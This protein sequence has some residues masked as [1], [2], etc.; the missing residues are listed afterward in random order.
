[1]VNIAGN[2]AD[3]NPNCLPDT[4]PASIGQE[5]GETVHFVRSLIRLL[6]IS[7]SIGI[8][9]AQPAAAAHRQRD[10]A[11]AATPPIYIG[12]HKIRT[13]AIVDRN[14]LLVPV[15]GVFEAV[16]ASVEYSR[17]KF[18]VVR[19]DGAVIAAFMLDRT[20]AVVGHASVDLDVA[21]MRRDGRVYV[22]L[23]VVAEAAGASVA[24]TNRPPAVHIR[25]AAADDA[26][27]SDET[28][29]EQSPST[30]QWRIG[31]AI[32]TG[33]CA[34]GCL[35]L[36]VRRFAPGVFRAAPLRGTVGATHGAAVPPREVVAGAAAVP[37][38]PLPPRPDRVAR[39]SVESLGE[40][41]LR[42][43]VV[44]E[45]RTIQVPITREEL[46]IEYTGGGGT[47]IIEGRELAAGETVRIP[48]WEE[49]VVVDVSKH[50]LRKE[51]IV[52][53]K[54]RSTFAVTHAERVQPL[55][56]GVAEGSP[57]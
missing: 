50:M 20:R 24:Y 33:L 8:L 30:A 10:R 54:R 31:V 36:A 55:D 44:T 11:A 12:T 38:A 23:R 17:P 51:D 40:A 49:R 35:V 3:S 43:E 14:H 45:T 18:V 56:F 5:F 21:P 16:G 46:V 52:V 57:S 4:P 15:R 25:P 39:T 13:A 2:R 6:G 26:P 47:V 19:K 27:M 48:L 29:V 41:R 22:P 9:V 28:S 32:F 7:L 1:V 37:A 34:L 53:D 42:K